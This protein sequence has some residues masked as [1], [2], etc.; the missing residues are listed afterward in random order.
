[1]Q[2]SNELGGGAT[3]LGAPMAAGPDDG[4]PAEQGTIKILTFRN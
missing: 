3:I 4:V 1:V 2:R